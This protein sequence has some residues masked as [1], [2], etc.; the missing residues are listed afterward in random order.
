MYPFI[1]YRRISIETSLTVS[2]AVNLLSASLMP[3]R[4]LPRLA[5]FPF[6]ESE[7]KFEGEVSD[8]GT[9]KIS[10]AIRY[11]NSFLPILYGVFVPTEQGVRVEVLMIL[12]S[13]TIAFLLAV[14][15]LLAAVAL[16][17]WSRFVWSVGN[18]LGIIGIVGFLLFMVFG[19]FG[20]E[21][22]KAERFIRQ[23]FEPYQTV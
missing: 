23:L 13:S 8:T 2:E 21:A 9:W 22:S 18:V 19:G 16:T 7:K 6:A 4:P 5:F 20:Y 15:G 12:H 14:Y 11:R 10:R 1:P 17:Q 3:K